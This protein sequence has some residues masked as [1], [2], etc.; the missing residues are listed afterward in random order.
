MAGC[1]L[2]AALE[3][4]AVGCLGDAHRGPQIGGLDETGVSQFSFQLLE[5]R[6]ALLQF[7]RQ[8][9]SVRAL[10]QPGRSKGGLHGE[11]VHADR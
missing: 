6:L 3:F 11:L 2:Q 10:G 4:A 7:S 8:Q 1:Q 5:Q 9:G